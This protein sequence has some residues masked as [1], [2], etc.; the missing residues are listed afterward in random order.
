MVVRQAA[1]P[2]PPDNP[3]KGWCPFTDAGPI[4]QPYGIP[5]PLRSLEGT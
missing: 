4:R 3:L 1:A 5:F 2:G